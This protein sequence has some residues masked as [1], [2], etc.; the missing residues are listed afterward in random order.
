MGSTF[1]SGE[2]RIAGLVLGDDWAKDLERCLLA[3]GD[4]ALL[5]DSFEFHRDAC[6][7]ESEIDILLDC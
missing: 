2:V 4:D 7:P 5:F 3:L 1:P 6:N